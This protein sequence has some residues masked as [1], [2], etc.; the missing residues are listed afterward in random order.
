V[1]ERDNREPGGSWIY[2][3]RAATL[4]KDMMWFPVMRSVGHNQL[5]DLRCPQ[6]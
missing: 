6:K 4:A 1:V 3:G 2:L 5:D